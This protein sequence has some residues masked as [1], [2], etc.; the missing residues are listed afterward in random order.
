[1]LGGFLVLPN[2]SAHQGIWTESPTPLL[3]ICVFPRIRAAA[4]LSL[5]NIDMHSQC[6]RW[7]EVVVRAEESV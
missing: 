6:E 2:K 1:L 4:W 3:L 5:T 7:I